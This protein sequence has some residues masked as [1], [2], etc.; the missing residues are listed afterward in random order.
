[1]HPFDT[2][3]GREARQL[4]YSA[5]ETRMLNSEYLCRA[6]LL[7][8]LLSS[9]SAVAAS[10]RF[11]IQVGVNHSTADTVFIGGHVIDQPPPELAGQNSFSGTTL[12]IGASVRVYRWLYL[13]AGWAEFVNEDRYTSYF[14]PPVLCPGGCPPDVPAFIEDNVFQSG[15]GYYIAIAPTYDHGPWRVMGKLGRAQTTI[16]SQQA[17][18]S[19]NRL[20]STERSTMYGVGAGYYF[21]KH[22][23]VR[24]DFEKLGSEAHQYG[25]SLSLRF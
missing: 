23:G 11:S 16:A 17:G 5:L 4:I 22:L 20:E 13:D 6:L 12:R 7:I 19:L 21:S 1:M 14:P 10:D 2:M 3:P 9:A 8:G 18:R 15:S 25:L 24:F